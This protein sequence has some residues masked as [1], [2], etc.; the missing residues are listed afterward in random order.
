MKIVYIAHPIGVFGGTSLEENIKSVIQI[1]RDIN[2]NMHEYV[3]F[4]PY[5]S[6]LY[7]LEDSVEDERERGLKNCITVIEKGFIDELWLYGNRISNG[8]WFEIKKCLELNIPVFAKTKETL[9]ELNYY[10]TKQ[11]NITSNGIIYNRINQNI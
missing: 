10:N 9:I 8:M 3:P 1:C 2:L 4:V 7:S 5:L 6:D 11:N